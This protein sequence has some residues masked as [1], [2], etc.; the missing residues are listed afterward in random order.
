MIGVTPGTVPPSG[1]PRIKLF[2]GIVPGWRA[3]DG[4]EPYRDQC[5]KSVRGLEH[6]LPLPGRTPRLARSPMFEQAFKNIDDV[7][8]KDAGCTSELDYTEQTSW[9]LFLKYLDA[10]STT[11]PPRPRS[12]ARNTP[13]SSTALSLGERGPRRRTRSGKIDHNTAL[14]GDDLIQFV[15]AKLFP[16]LHGFKQG[17]RPEH[18]RIQD[19]RDLRRDQEP[20]PERLQPARGHR[21][22]RRTALPLADREARALAP[23]RS[24]DQKHGQRRAQRRRVLHPA[25]AHPRHRRCHRAPARRDHLRRGR[26]LGGLPLRILRLPEARRTPSAP[27][28]RTAPCRSA[29][30]TGRKRSPSPT[31]SRS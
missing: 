7:L 4:H 3:G 20:H 14:T 18:H 28:P 13:T 23:L 11:R 26:R 19:R 30:S 10:S 17:H 5:V 2:D 12:T 16:Y 21:P 24:Q 15:N 9:L 31:S 1:F 8:W 29:P 25:P 22:H 27:P 6:P